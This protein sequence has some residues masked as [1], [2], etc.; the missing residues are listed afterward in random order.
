[1]FK[2]ITTNFWFIQ[3]I[4]IVALLFVILAWNARTRNGILL[5]Q[6]LSSLFF[7]AHFYLLGAYTGALMSLIV[8]GRNFV[9]ENKLTW[10]RNTIWLYLF[11]FFSVLALLFSWQGFISVFPVL[12]VIIGTYAVWKNNPKD[13]RSYMLLTAVIW[14][15]YTIV[16]HSYSG[17]ISQVVMAVAILIGKARLDRHMGGNFEKN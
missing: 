11:M 14:I 8:V 2:I 12:G 16:V 15:P 9:F 7:V 4:G 5:R 3:S 17:L 13:M 10:A 6:G 1:M